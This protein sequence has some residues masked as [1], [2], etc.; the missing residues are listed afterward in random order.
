MNQLKEIFKKMSLLLAALVFLAFSFGSLSFKHQHILSDGTL[1][2]HSHP[3]SH[4][5]GGQ[6]QH[7]DREITFLASLVPHLDL[8]QDVLEIQIVTQQLFLNT[9]I[10]SEESIHLIE[11]PRNILRGPPTFPSFL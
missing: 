4:Q 10:Y 5:N 7:S 2:E 6:H 3:F 9:I 11:L 8:V 1:I